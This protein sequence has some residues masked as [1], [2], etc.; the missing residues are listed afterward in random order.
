MTRK[1][2][3]S[4]GFSNLFRFAGFSILLL[5]LVACSK[6]SESGSGS[7]EHPSETVLRNAVLDEGGVSAKA[8]RSQ[9]LCDLSYPHLQY[10]A[11]RNKISHDG[12]SSRSQTIENEG[13]TSTGEIVAY[14]S[15]RNSEAQQAAACA[16]SWRTSSEHWKLMS[17]TWNYACYAMLTQGNRT[18][19]IGLFANG[20]LK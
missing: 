13:G 7:S 3:L 18:Y 5:A 10:M 16:H 6:D 8:S 4:A 9:E 17:K 20:K 15:G 11:D 14:N 2:T 1:G 12:Y 19:C